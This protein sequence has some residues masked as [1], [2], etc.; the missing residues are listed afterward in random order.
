MVDTVNEVD[1]V[2]QGFVQISKTK[3]LMRVDT[4]YLE[5]QQKKSMRCMQTMF[6]FLG[7]I[8]SRGTC[9]VSPVK[10]SIIPR[11]FRVLIFSKAR[12]ES[13]HSRGSLG[14]S[15]QVTLFSWSL[16]VLMSHKC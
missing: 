16:E 12:E 9:Y 13:W 8:P 3:Y 15:R 6:A 4:D 14:R 1:S 10:S 5:T 2:L 11:H 7:Q